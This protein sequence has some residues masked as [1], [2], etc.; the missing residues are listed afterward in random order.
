[1]ARLTKFQR[2]IAIRPR[3]RYG[4]SLNFGRAYYGFTRFGDDNPLAGVYRRSRFADGKHDSIVP[5]YFP[6]NP[7]TVPQ[8]A[9]RAVFTAGT[10]AWG[11]LTPTE[12][13]PYTLR[14]KRLHRTAFNVYMSDYLAKHRL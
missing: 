2:V 6:S 14:G 8:Q 9:W 3:G 5:I 7:Q 10:V 4:Y 11:A 12:I 13:A 1:M